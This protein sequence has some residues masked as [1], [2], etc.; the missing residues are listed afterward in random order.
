MGYDREPP[1]AEMGHVFPEPFAAIDAVDLRP[2]VGKTLGRGRACETDNAGNLTQYAPQCLETEGGGILE[3]REFV[4]DH[5]VEGEFLFVT[6]AEPHNRIAP[7]NVDVG[8]RLQRGATLTGTSDDVAHSQPRQVVPLRRLAA[9]CGFGDFLWSYH[10]NL[11]RL[12]VTCQP[13]DR[14]QTYHRFAESHLK[15]KKTARMTDDPFESQP[16]VFVGDKSHDSPL[17]FP[18]P[19]GCRGFFH[20]SMICSA[21]RRLSQI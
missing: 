10:Q 11:L 9:P 1:L 17:F 5:H 2:E 21:L 7:D 19:P 18:R 15:E 14:A 3:T 16:L 6:L 4:D 12:A 8:I 20:L 13:L